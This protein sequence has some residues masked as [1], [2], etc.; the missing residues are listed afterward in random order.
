M[1]SV[2]IDPNEGKAVE[3]NMTQNGRGEAANR[4][5]FESDLDRKWLLF[6]T[7]GFPIL[8]VGLM[9]VWIQHIGLNEPY[10]VVLLFF[11][12][13]LAACSAGIVLAII[14]AVPSVVH[15]VEVKEESQKTADAGYVPNASFGRVTEWVTSAITGVTL[16]SLYPAMSGFWAFTGEIEPIAK[17]ESLRAA[18][19]MTTG[20]LAICAFVGAYIKARTV[21]PALISKSD[22]ALVEALRKLR[23]EEEMNRKAITQMAQ[24]LQS[25]RA[26][27]EK[28]I[29]QKTAVQIGLLNGFFWMAMDGRT[30]GALNRSIFHFDEV[31][32]R[33]PTNPE[34]L[35]EKARAHKIRN[36]PGDLQKAVL[37]LTRAIDSGHSDPV[38]FYNRAC[39]RALSGEPVAAWLDDLRAAF[40]SN[41]R[42]REHA[43]TD[44]ELQ[45]AQDDLQF[46]ALLGAPVGQS[47][48]SDSPPSR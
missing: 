27:I 45:S 31:L 20:A 1:I 40:S 42:Y 37:M 33:N 21:L 47:Q 36:G 14:F 3:N 35:R 17:H 6:W 24:N 9:L 41:P 7:T 43:R 4:V 23:T 44:P 46:Q 18:L 32:A 28:I 12:F 48:A 2:A 26:E 15:Q 25:D 22:A 19:C 11:S 16:V 34:A 29:D 8:L 5:K 10:Q 13:G 39:Y 30:Q 38:F